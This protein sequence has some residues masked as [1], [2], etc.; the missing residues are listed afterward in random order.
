MVR[1]VLDARDPEGSRCPHGG[2]QQEAGPAAARLPSPPPP[3]AKT[4]L[5]PEAGMAWLKPLPPLPAPRMPQDP[6]SGEAWLPILELLQ[7]LPRS[8]RKVGGGG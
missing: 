2:S 1:F 5:P 4:W 6:P 7:Q 3:P 8:S